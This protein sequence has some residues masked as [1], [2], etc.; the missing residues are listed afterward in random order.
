MDSI[1]R[2]FWNYSSLS[3]VN[4]YGLEDQS[5]FPR[6]GSDSATKPA[7]GPIQWLLEDL[8]S[9]KLLAHFRGVVLKY[10]GNFNGK[11]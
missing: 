8:G 1:L 6:R 3:K 4:D 9:L 2:Y 10:R 11:I 5:Y 7:L